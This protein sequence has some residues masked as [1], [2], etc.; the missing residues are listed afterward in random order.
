MSASRSQGAR[1]GSASARRTYVAAR[2]SCAPAGCTPVPRRPRPCLPPSHLLPRR[3]HRVDQSRT[4]PR[5]SRR[6]PFDAVSMRAH[7]RTAP[8]S[9][10]SC[11]H[12]WGPGPRPLVAQSTGTIAAAAATAPEVGAEPRTCEADVLVH[13][14]HVRLRPEQGRTRDAV[15]ICVELDD[16]VELGPLRA[17]DSGT[18]TLNGR[19]VPVLRH[20]RW[21]AQWRGGK[22]ACRAR[23]SRMVP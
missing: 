7:M 11:A 21:S 13:A 23:C 6:A 9:F 4:S 17:R 12:A 2:A 14:P 5:P 3:C 8:A 22:W 10:A 15:R 18:T 16:M 1:A 20:S 19:H